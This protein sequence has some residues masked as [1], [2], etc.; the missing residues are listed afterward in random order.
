MYSDQITIVVAVITNDKNEVL[1]AKRHQP[2][3]PQ[4]HNKWEFPGGGIELGEEPIEAIKREVREEVGVEIKVIRLLPK[5]IS[6]TQPSPNGGTRQVLIIS[7]ECKI[8]SGVPTANLDEEITE[9]KFYPFDEVKNLN[10][11]F[12]THP[13]LQLITND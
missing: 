1:L 12:N 10:T 13:T 6:D 8:I 11:F 2:D 3:F 5:I 7:Y 4:A 9:L